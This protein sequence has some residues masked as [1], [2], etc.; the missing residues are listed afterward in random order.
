MTFAVPPWTKYVEP[1]GMVAQ[2]GGQEVEKEEVLFFPTSPSAKPSGFFSPDSPFALARY[3]TRNTHTGHNT[4]ARSFRSDLY[5]FVRHQSI[6]L[7]T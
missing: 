7:Q 4:I 5:F 6:G 2:E 3:H 1:L